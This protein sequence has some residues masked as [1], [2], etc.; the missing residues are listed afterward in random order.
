M[1]VYIVFFGSAVIFATVF[2]MFSFFHDV[3]SLFVY[4]LIC[5]HRGPHGRIAITAKRVILL[6]HCINK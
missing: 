5:L 4:K 1:N 2:M 3:I 6:K